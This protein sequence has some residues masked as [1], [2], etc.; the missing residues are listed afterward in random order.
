[1]AFLANRDVNLLSLHYGFQA[2]AQGSGGVFLL[3][4]LL[5]SGLSVPETILALAATVLIRL[6]ARRAVTPFATRFGLKATLI[7]GCLVMALQYPLTAAVDGIGMWLVARCLASG[8]GEAF[9]WT[10]F[11]AYFASVGDSEHRGRQIG[12]REALAAGIGVVAPLF[13]AWALMNLKA[14][15]AFAAIGGI[16][17]LGV[18]PLLWAPSVAVVRDAP[19]MREA[20]RLGSLVYLANGWFAATFVL[21][22]QV[23]LFLSLSESLSAYG[24]TMAIAAIAGGIGGLLLG[25][26]LDGGHGATATRI[27]FAGIAAMVVLRA[28]SLGFPGLAIAANAAGAFAICFY[29]PAIN[30]PV[31]NLA[32]ASPCSLR[33]HVATEDSWDKGALAACAATIILL[34]AGAGLSSAILL[35]LV[36]CAAHAVLLDRYYLK[37]S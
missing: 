18:V 36:S 30:T 1:M 35:A 32:K 14:G 34:W 28:S 8:I 37:N 22:W 17:A 7:L 5:K 4:I 24:G 10:S 20:T 21:V 13:G 9:Y 29:V 2:L 16:Q 3:V 23:A 27:I 25:R 11:H 26:I 15:A 12:A 33:F 19:G 6:V 31:Y